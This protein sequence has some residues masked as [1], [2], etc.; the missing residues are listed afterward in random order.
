MERLRRIVGNTFISLLG[1]VVTW[2]STLVLTIAYGRFLSDTAFG[3][4]Y[5]AITFVA[6][7]GFPLEFGFNQQLTRDVAQEPE[8]A[9]QYLSNILLL[10]A[11]FWIIL[12][13]L[14]MLLSFL[15]GYRGEEI[16]LIIIAGISLLADAIANVFSS[17]HYALERV[18]FPVV[19]GILQKGLSALI[20]TIFLKYGASVEVMALILLGSSFVNTF[21]QAIWGLRAAGLPFA[22]S[23]K[24]IIHLLRT[25]IPFLVYGVLAVIYYRIDTV[26]LSF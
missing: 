13:A 25:C 11:C 8:K 18:S 12:F 5:L 7:V 17:L 21:W 19:G 14:I 6:L 4:L 20:G 9:Q 10:K 23:G 15:L 26:L 2:T 24:L 22:F 1:Q 16:P 3:E